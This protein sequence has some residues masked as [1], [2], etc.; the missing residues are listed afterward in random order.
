MPPTLRESPANKAAAVQLHRQI[1]TVLRKCYECVRLSGEKP[2]PWHLRGQAA[3]EPRASLLETLG[4]P[5]M[6]RAMRT[7][8]ETRRDKSGRRSPSAH[9]YHPPQLTATLPSHPST[10]RFS[11]TA[12]V[13]VGRPACLKTEKNDAHTVTWKLCHWDTGQSQ[14][15]HNTLVHHFAKCRSTCKYFHW[16]SAVNL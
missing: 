9:W 2:A 14:K 7:A 13:Y 5:L 6:T 15:C 10:W 3:A 1:N 4:D 16:D 11:S 12:S 8:S